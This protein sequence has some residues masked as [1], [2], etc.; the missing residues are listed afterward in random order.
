MFLYAERAQNMRLTHVRW[1]T[2]DPETLAFG[3]FSSVPFRN[4]GA[5]YNRPLVAID[6]D[7]AGNLYIVSAFDPEA[8]M[9]PDPD[10][11]PFASAVWRIGVVSLDREGAPIVTLDCRPTLLATRDGFKVESVAVREDDD[12]VQLFVGTDDENY[13]ATI[14][15]LPQAATPGL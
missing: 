13:G 10:N 15:L 14:R 9:L 7:D 12:G 3:P 8:A 11:G 5:A 2:L 1:A 6:I 4:P